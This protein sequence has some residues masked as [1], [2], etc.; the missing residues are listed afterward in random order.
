MILLYS[1]ST[2]NYTLPKMVDVRVE[3]KIQPTYLIKVLHS[4]CTSYNL[5]NKHYVEIA[6]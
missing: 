2:F 1:V 4:L 6:A 5:L 3:I